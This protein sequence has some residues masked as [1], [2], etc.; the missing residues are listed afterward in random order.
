M[1]TLQP[2]ELET[3]HRLVAAD[4]LDHRRRRPLLVDLRGAQK[5]ALEREQLLVHLHPVLGVLEKRRRLRVALPRQPV[6]GIDQVARDIARISP[7]HAPLLPCSATAPRSLLSSIPPE[8]E[9]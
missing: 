7:A 4:L 2:P 1:P 9:L 6:I 3:E 5:G 8:H